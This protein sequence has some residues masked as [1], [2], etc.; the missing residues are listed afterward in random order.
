VTLCKP[1]TPSTEVPQQVLLLTTAGSAGTVLYLSCQLCHAELET[2]SCCCL[3]AT[4]GSV[5]PAAHRNC[6]TVWCAQCHRLAGAGEC[7]Q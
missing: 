2:V 7:L 3:L 5:P 6:K 4:G 1:A